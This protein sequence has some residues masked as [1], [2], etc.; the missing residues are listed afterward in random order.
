MLPKDEKYGLKNQITRAAVSKPS[1]I[2][3]R[4]SR[5]RSKDFKRYLEISLDS[6]FELETQLIIV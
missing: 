3:E 2:A 6:T 4:S 5:S 1:N